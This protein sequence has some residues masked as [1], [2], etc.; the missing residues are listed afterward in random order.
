MSEAT[1]E[2]TAAELLEQVEDLEA[3]VAVAKTSVVEATEAELA[4]KRLA[5]Q[6]ACEAV[7][8]ANAEIL[9]L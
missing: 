3:A 2:A 1:I 4:T 7:R 5:Y 8:K 9:S 6:V